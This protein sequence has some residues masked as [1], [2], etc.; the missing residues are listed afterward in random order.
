MDKQGDSRPASVPA[1]ARES[2]AAQRDQEERLE[3][4]NGDPDAPAAQQ[5]N[6]QIADESTR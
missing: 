4:Q 5:S 3:H 6:D 1:D 2:T